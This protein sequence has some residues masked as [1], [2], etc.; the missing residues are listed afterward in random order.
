MQLPIIIGLH[1]SSLLLG[2]FL[3]VAMAAMAAV[4]LLPLAPVWRAAFAALLALLLQR[5]WGS[6]RASPSRLRLE[7][8]G[9][10]SVALTASDDFRPACCLPGATVHPWLCVF[11]LREAASGARHV[12]LVT[13]DS[14]AADEFRRLRV[15]LRWRA[16]FSCSPSAPA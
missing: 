16:V 10:V 4:W 5:I 11:R 1:R 9:S 15:F 7:R 2:V 3:A 12:V 13:S 14:M 6:L 8:D